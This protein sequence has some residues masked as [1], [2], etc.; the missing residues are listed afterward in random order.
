M[1]SMLGK[2]GFAC[3]DAF[4]KSEHKLKLPNLELP[5]EV[6]ALLSP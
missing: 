2:V 6:T 5:A 3:R 1:P 4:N